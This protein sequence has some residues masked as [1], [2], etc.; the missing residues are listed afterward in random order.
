MPRLKLLLLTNEPAHGGATGQINGYELMALSGEIES[1][2]NTSH[3]EGYDDLS[4]YDRVLNAVQRKDYDVIVIWS[5]VVFPNTLDQF[6]EIIKAIN[7]RPILYWEGDPWQKKDGKKPVTNQMSWWMSHSE[8]VFSTATSPHF[9]IFRDIG[10]KTIVHMPNTYCHLFF[11]NEEY[12][13]PNS[14]GTLRDITMIANN[15]ARIPGV[16]GLPG[17]L[18]RIEL[19]SRLHFNNK[20][21]H[22]IFGRGWPKNWSSGN[23]PYSKQASEIRKSKLSVNW[24]N[25]IDYHDYSSDRLPISLIAGR[26]HITTRHPG[27]NWA[28]NSEHGL[29]QEESPKKIIE[30]AE[31]ILFSDPENLFKLGL[32]GHNWVKNRL[33]HREAAR[34]V[35]SSYFE[36]IKKPPED[37]WSNL[38]R[39]SY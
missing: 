36:N 28:P 32:E 37:P 19:A 34:Y 7:G 11:K 6:A 8:I 26:I 18:K 15:S 23:V 20:I 10:A 16:S 38:K 30:K 12:L 39:I 27:M 35:L 5:P 25:F 24:D 29:F 21:S 3:R 9:E 4:A 17:T 2:K 1:C 13:S 31:N 33:S 14:L 22:N